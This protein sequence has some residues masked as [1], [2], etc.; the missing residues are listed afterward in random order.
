MI[1]FNKLATDIGMLFLVATSTFVKVC[2]KVSFDMNPLCEVAHILYAFVS[3]FIHYVSM[4]I[5]E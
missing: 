4:V 3:E 5:G 2:D 1:F